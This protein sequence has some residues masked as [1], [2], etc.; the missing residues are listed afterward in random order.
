MAD[1]KPKTEWIKPSTAAT[2]F[3]VSTDTLSRMVKAGLIEVRYF[4]NMGS[5]H[6]IRYSTNSIRKNLI[7]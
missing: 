3:D 6:G 7:Q 4:A 2:M 5:R 1:R